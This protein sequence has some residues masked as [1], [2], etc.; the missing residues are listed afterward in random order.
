[1][2]IIPKV[3]IKNLDPYPRVRCVEFNRKIF[4]GR[5]ELIH[6]PSYKTR[7]N[8]RPNICNKSDE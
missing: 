8:R 4:V 1:M 3:L 6:P 5:M 7:N 2:N